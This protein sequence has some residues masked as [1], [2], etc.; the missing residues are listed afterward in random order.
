[1]SSVFGFLTIPLYFIVVYKSE[2]MV[3]RMSVTF[4]EASTRESYQIAW[5]NSAS[6]TN[7]TV[8]VA[9]ERGNIVP[10]LWIECIVF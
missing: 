9:E 1:M 10:M 7:G 8:C 3:R 6:E 2:S 5:E 4:D